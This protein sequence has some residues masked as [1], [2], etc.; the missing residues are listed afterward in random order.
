MTA[1][2]EPAPEFRNALEAEIIRALRRDVRTGPLML[3]RR[4]QRLRSAAILA[5][6]VALGAAA[7]A[8]P[9]QVQDA[10]QREQLTSVAQAE[11]QVLLMRYDLARVAYAEAHARFEVGVI[12]RESLAAAEAELRS[13]ESR[14]ARNRID[15]EEIRA[16][17]APP[18]DEISAPLVGDRD[19][20]TERLRL[21]LRGAQR[22]L[23]AAEVAV[24]E[25]ERRHRVG[26]ATRA[27]LL[28][29]QIAHARAKSEMQRLAGMLNLRQAFIEQSLPVAEV[30]RRAQRHELVV[31]AELARVLHDFAVDRLA[32]LREQL[33]LGQ[34]VE[35]EVMRAN[36]E[37]MER[38][39]EKL[40]IARRLEM[41]DTAR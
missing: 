18:R 24:G 26:A 21:D 13:M 14:V 23:T 32:F 12:G 10:R 36:V 4:R 38:A 8:A 27:A 35:L 25:A 33:A 41:L 34:A 39:M 6:A 29:P 40:Q 15:L 20:V 22:Q 19:F 37:V 17:A 31:E 28:E 30:E 5:A 16:A 1:L 7:G 11:Q 2:H 3:T 9:A